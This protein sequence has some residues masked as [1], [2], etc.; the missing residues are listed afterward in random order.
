MNKFDISIL[1]AGLLFSAAAYGQD[2]LSREVDVTRSYEP[3]VREVL[4]INIMPDLVDTAQMRPEFHYEITPRPL[5]YGFAVDPLQPAS[6][7]TVE[8]RMKYPFYVKA[9][10]GGPLQSTAGFRYATEFN[11]RS[12]FGA[13]LDHYGFYG[14]IKNDAEVKAPAT[15]TFNKAGLFKDNRIGEDLYFGAKLDYEFNRVSRYGYHNYGNPVH[16]AFDDTKKGLSQFFHYLSGDVAVGNSFD[17]LSKFNF[18][19]GM[20]GEYFADRF[21]YDQFTYRVNGQAGFGVG[22]ESDIRIKVDYTTVNG[23]NHYDF[24]SNNILTAG[25]YFHYDNGNFRF[26]L[27]A[28]YGHGNVA[29]NEYLKIKT[30]SFLPAFDIEFGI[31]GEQLRFFGDIQSKIVNNSYGEIARINPYAASGISPDNSVRYD[32]IAGVKGTLGGLFKYRLFGGFAHLKNAYYFYNLYADGAFGNTF[33]TLT[34]DLNVVQFGA[35]AEVLLW[36]ALR[37][38]G[39]FRYFDYSPDLY[40][41]AGGMPEFKSRIALG[42]QSR[43]RFFIEVGVDILGER[44]FYES[45]PG[46]ADLYINRIDPVANLGVKTEYRIDDRWGVFLQLDNLLG[47]DLYPFNRY[48]SVGLNGMAGVSVSF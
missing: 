17:D 41:Y 9:G 46:T 42:Y 39:D 30:S 18:S 8:S 40:D 5:D 14:K 47:Q 19:V 45:F 22:Y 25:A 6:V 1:A 10:L 24:Y 23:L 7:N 11:P 34:D 27:G 36:N 2:N 21:K 16:S 44:T 43:N 37:V 13:Y 38:S 28:D 29:V 3:S 20:R 15:S 4:K 33:G 48:R 26:R 31:I 35:E 12:S 32:G